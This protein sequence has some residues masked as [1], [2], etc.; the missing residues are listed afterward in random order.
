MVCV[1]TTFQPVPTRG[2]QQDENYREFM[3]WITNGGLRYAYAKY[4]KDPE[5]DTFF[6]EELSEENQREVI[7][8]GAGMSGL[9]AAYELAQV[10]HKVNFVCSF[11]VHSV[12]FKKDNLRGDRFETVSVKAICRWRFKTG[13][14]MHQHLAKQILI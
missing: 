3:G 6:Q 4:H 8:I 11:A 2:I 13:P 5:A 9:A 7:I 1:I 10:G 12:L 14:R